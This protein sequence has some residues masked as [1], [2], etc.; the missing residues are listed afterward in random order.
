MPPDVLLQHLRSCR[1]FL[2]LTKVTSQLGID[3]SWFTYVSSKNIFI[4]IL[5][6]RNS[7]LSKLYFIEN[8]FRRRFVIVE[9]MFPR[10]YIWSKSIL[11]EVL[12]DRK[13]FPPKRIKSLGR[14]KRIKRVERSAK[15]WSPDENW[16]CFA[17]KAME[18]LFQRLIFHSEPAQRP[19]NSDLPR[20]LPVLPIASPPLALFSLLYINN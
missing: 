16:P 7:S 5:F 17:D 10:K 18:D 8:T 9:N 2:A 3:C 19:T 13:H 15:C 14:I 20:I 12:F 4:E 6:Y 1:F 11:N